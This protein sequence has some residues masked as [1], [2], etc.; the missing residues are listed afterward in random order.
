[1]KTS[2][3]R[4]YCFTTAFDRERNFL[5]MKAA[6]FVMEICS[7]FKIQYFNKCN[8]YFMNLVSSLP[9]NSYHSSE[10]ET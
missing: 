4:Q 3:E 7:T 8:Q 9:T 1:M 5:L 10:F 2:Q 6:L